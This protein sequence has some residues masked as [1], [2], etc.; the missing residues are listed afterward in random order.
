[1]REKTDTLPKATAKRLPLYLR[2][3]KML[4]DSG[5]SRIKSNEFSEITQFLLQRSAE[6]SRN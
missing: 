1:M 2:Y 4:D 5:I 6:T 3:L